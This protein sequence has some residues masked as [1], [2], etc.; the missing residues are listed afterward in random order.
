[1]FLPQSLAHTLGCIPHHPIVAFRKV[2][3]VGLGHQ[4][5]ETDA[6]Q[7]LARTI[8][9]VCLVVRTRRFHATNLTTQLDGDVSNLPDG[10]LRFLHPLVAKTD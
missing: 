2:I 6:F 10:S 3:S 7:T 8:L 1:M 9:D 5:A 4:R